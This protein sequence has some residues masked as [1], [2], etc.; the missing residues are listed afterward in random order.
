MI[1]FISLFSFPVTKYKVHVKP[2]K[3]VWSVWSRDSTSLSLYTLVGSGRRTEQQFHKET[4]SRYEL[5]LS[6]VGVIL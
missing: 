3:P 1:L 2:V 4:S 5:R 6:K